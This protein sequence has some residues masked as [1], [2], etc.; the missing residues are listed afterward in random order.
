[1]NLPGWPEFL[2]VIPA[3]F[4]YMAPTIVA[5]YRQTDNIFAVGLVNFFLGGTGIGWIVALVMATR[6]PRQSAFR[7]ELGR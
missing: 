2:Y 3:F 7:N 4:L 1:M 5:I 6:R